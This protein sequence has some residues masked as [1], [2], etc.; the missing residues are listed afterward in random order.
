MIY[1]SDH[2]ESLGE[3]G[4]YLHSMPYVVAP[5]EQTH[6]PYISWFSDNFLA[7]HHLN[8]LCLKQHAN[9]PYSHDYLFHSIL[10]L[11]N[12]SSNIYKPQLDIYASCRRNHMQL[13][14][15]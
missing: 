11:M 1:V 7:D 2:G 12:V 10:G 8:K 6:V 3:N 13:S 9:E 14:M 5:E 15:R 4:I